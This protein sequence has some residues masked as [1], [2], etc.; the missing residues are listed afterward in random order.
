MQETNLPQRPKSAKAQRTRQKILEAARA[1]FAEYGFAKATAEEISTKAGVGYGTFYLYFAD[2]RQALHTILAEVDD[3]LYQ[4]GQSEGV[5][6]PCLG[7]GA[8]A[9][10]KATIGG[11]FDSFKAYADVLKIC[12]ELS[13]TDPDFKNQ[14]DK[15]RARLV[16]RIKEHILKGIEFGNARNL[17]PEITSMAIAGMVE[18]IAVEW[19]FNNREWNREKVINTVAKLYYGAVV[20][21]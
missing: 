5:E 2:K 3:K 4:L 16:D 7:L 10:I 19:F 17:D 6:K 9:P 20:K 13:A 1:V 18:T 8:L 21:S 12:H 15:V 14:H 11:F